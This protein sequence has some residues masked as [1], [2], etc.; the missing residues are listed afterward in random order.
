M[1]FPS[2]VSDLGIVTVRPTSLFF[3]PVELVKTI[4]GVVPQVVELLN[5]T[6]SM[7]RS[8]AVTALGKLSKQCK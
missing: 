7:V 8:S 5:D 2:I 4:E 1:K 3:F 6:D